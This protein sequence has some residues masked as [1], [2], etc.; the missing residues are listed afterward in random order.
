MDDG[1]P[2]IW[3]RHGLNWTRAFCGIADGLRAI[4][5]DVVIDG[6]AV[7]QL[8]DGR[9]DFHALAWPDGCARAVLFA[10]DLLAVG[11]EDLR[12]LPLEI[13]R[14]RLAALLADA[15]PDG[16]AFS[17]GQDEEGEALFAAACRLGLEGVVAKRKGRPYVSGRCRS[18]L[19]IK[20]PRFERPVTS[21]R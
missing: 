20:N 2:R 5:R 19:K 16:V 3:S 1:R 14:E 15:K 18:W 7:C 6:E 8:E 21:M 11:G 12:G 17:D 13:R 10:F 4:G 9:S